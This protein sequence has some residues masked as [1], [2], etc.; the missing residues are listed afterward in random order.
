[1]FEKSSGVIRIS[2]KLYSR[3]FVDDVQGESSSEAKEDIPENVAQSV[4]RSIATSFAQSNASFLK[5][6]RSQFQSKELFDLSIY[7]KHLLQE[8]NRVDRKKKEVTALIGDLKS[9]S[10]A[11]DQEVL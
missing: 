1:M 6:R 7:E 10:V 4:S 8:L 9:T 5:A 2:K 3:K 11:D